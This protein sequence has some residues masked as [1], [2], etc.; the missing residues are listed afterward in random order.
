[1]CRG[2][3]TGL[4]ALLIRQGRL[5]GIIGGTLVKRTSLGMPTR[6]WLGGLELGSQRT[7][8]V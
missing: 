6:T 8:R 4:Q 2:I 1:M 3:L 5:W 7:P